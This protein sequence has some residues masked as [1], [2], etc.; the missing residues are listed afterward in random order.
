MLKAIVETKP[1]M[2]SVQN[3]LNIELKPRMCMKIEGPNNDEISLAF[4]IAQ[5][6]DEGGWSLAL[7][8]VMYYPENGHGVD[9]GYLSAEG[10]LLALAKMLDYE[11]CRTPTT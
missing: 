8:N 10:L 7:H 3:G 9:H 6:R 11:V 5:A 1:P 4:E 2:R